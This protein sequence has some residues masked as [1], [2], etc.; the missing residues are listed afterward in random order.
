TAMM[1]DAGKIR[2][3]DPVSQDVAG[4]AV[5]D[6]YV[7][8]ELTIRDLLTHELGF[9]DPDYLW[10][11]HEPDRS[12]TDMTRRLRYVPPQTT[13]RSH[14]A[15]NNVG[16]AVAGLAAASAAGTTW[17]DLVRTRILRPL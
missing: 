5:R 15:Y 1:V 12:L 14:F 17:Q 11:G 13:L 10:Y 7:S 8:R 6:P 4:F 9:A 2:W 3:S 16:Y